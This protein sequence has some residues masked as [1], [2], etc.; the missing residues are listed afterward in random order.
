ML[1]EALRYGIKVELS[2][3]GW[4]APEF[5]SSMTGVWRI[6]EV[7]PF[8]RLTYKDPDSTKR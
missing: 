5:K 2:I 3:K 7:Y 6:L 1:Y 8:R 4:G